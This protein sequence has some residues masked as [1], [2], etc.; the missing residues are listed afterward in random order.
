LAEWY[1]VADMQMSDLVTE[2]QTALMD[3]AERFEGKLDTI[4]TAALRDFS[5][6]KPLTLQAEIT[7]QPGVDVYDAPADLIDVK[8]H[9]WGSMQRKLP[10]WDPAYPRQ[11]PRL[12]VLDGEPL[13][14]QLST[15]PTGNQIANLGNRFR[16]TYYA[17]RAVTEGWVPVRGSDIDILLVRAQAEAMRWLAN[18]H[19]D[20][21]V[22][23]RDVVGSTPRNG[24]PAALCELYTKQ[25]KEM[26]RA[27]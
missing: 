23:T 12:L 24:T 19:V 1:L 22:S 16:F 11:L 10:F 2:L 17:E 21:A 14:L 20:R 15:A 25:F 18:Q 4:I 26:L 9:S 3:S 13:Q 27:A 8:T 6:R 7:L 5:R